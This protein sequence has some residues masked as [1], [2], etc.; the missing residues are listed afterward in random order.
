MKSS[1]ST[2]RI[3]NF[4]FRNPEALGAASE[5]GAFAV[6]IRDGVAR[7]VAAFVRVLRGVPF[8]SRSR[9]GLRS[10]RFLAQ[11][12]LLLA[13]HLLRAGE[14]RG[15]RRLDVGVGGG[16]VGPRRR[17][18]LL[19]LLLLAARRLGLF[20]LDGAVL[21][22]RR[23]R[24]RAPP[25]GALGARARG[26]PGAGDGAKSVRESASPRTPS[27]AP[28]AI[29][30]HR[31][32]AR[33]IEAPARLPAL[34][35]PRGACFRWWAC[36][37]GVRVGSASSDAGEPV[38]TRARGP[39]VGPVLVSFSRRAGCRRAGYDVERASARGRRGRTPADIPVRVPGRAAAA[40]AY[41]GVMQALREGRA[42]APCALGVAWE[43]RAPPPR[44]GASSGRYLYR[45]CVRASRP[46]PFAARRD[47]DRQPRAP[48]SSPPR[49]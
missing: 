42:G 27:P 3:P 25:R 19:L 15:G 44:R 40:G 39:A 7:L 47:S 26:A 17:L 10:G 32:E 14:G 5:R 46:R 11:L 30:T 37:G 8:S 43:V 16:G 48:T 31:G 29:D 33:T 6:F 2:S 34:S 22:V 9:L 1:L 24:A 49:R 28:D 20:L 35:R 12:L 18:L 45:T 23:G 4:D 36:V 21:S 41:T 38:G 13:R